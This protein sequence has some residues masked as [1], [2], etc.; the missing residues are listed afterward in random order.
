MLWFGLTQIGSHSIGQ[1]SLKP[2]AQVILLSRW[3]YRHTPPYLAYKY[4]LLNTDA[5]ICFIWS[6]AASVLQGRVK[7][8]QQRPMSCKAENIYYLVLSRKSLPTLVLSL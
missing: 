2:L 7:S 8:L 5:S 1:A 4:F 6:V 3:D